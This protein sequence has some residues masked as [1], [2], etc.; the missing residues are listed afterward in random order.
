MKTSLKSPRNSS[1][2][3]RRTVCEA[4]DSCTDG[5]PLP[6]RLPVRGGRGHRVP[7]R[8]VSM[9]TR[10]AYPPANGV[11]VTG[12]FPRSYGVAW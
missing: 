9:P 10:I 12:S 3:S 6:G 1:H 4:P 2:E 5:E 8:G 11:S 7:A